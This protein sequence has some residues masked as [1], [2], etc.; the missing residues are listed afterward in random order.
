MSQANQREVKNKSILILAGAP[1][2]G[3]KKVTKSGPKRSIIITSERH[4]AYHS[5]VSFI[6]EC[7]ILKCFICSFHFSTVSFISILIS[8]NECWLPELQSWRWCERVS[9]YVSLSNSLCV[10]LYGHCWCS[11]LSTDPVIQDRLCYW[12]DSTCIN[13]INSTCITR[14]LLTMLSCCRLCNRPVHAYSRSHHLIRVP[15]SSFN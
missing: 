6:F 1:F 3:R 12:P 4:H 15:K 14:L 5:G 11:R 13:S 2:L 9:H 7:F 8:S 10:S